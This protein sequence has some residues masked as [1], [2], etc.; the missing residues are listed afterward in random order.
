MLTDEQIARRIFYYFKTMPKEQRATILKT[1]NWMR[2]DFPRLSIPTGVN[3]ARESILYDS[4]SKAFR[5]VFQME[6]EDVFRTKSRMRAYTNMRH[7]AVYVYKQRTTLSTLQ[8]AERLCFDRS[9]IYNALEK[10]ASHRQVYRYF[11]DALTRLE[12]L[13][14]KYYNEALQELHNEEGQ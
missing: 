8:W 5:D 9:S 13:T 12:K 11:N 7:M 6:M 1:I 3:E 14:D 10:V 2:Y 4:L